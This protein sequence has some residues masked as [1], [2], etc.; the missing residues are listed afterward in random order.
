[1]KEVF[2][3][4]SITKDVSLHSLRH[5]YATHLLKEGA[6]IVII[7]ELLGHADTSTTMFYLHVAQCP[8][9]SAHCLLDKLYGIQ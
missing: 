9:I 6:N 3:K 4:T 7:K 1:M 8:I 2:K 5:S